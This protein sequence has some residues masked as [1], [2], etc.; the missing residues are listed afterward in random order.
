MQAKYLRTA[1]HHMMSRLGDP[2]KYFGKGQI[3]IL[4]VLVILMPSITM[5]SFSIKLENTF[6]KKMYY[7]VYWI[8]HPFTWSGPANMAGGELKALESVEIPIN[9]DSGKY[10]VIWRDKAE[11]RNKL[12][13][14]IVKKRNKITIN[15]ESVI[16]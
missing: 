14:D 2:M 6:D 9:Y 11:W 3:I 10:Y 12:R 4:V 5:A 16:F 13:F 15:P 8:D 7:M 1:V